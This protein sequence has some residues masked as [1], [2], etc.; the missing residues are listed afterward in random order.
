MQTFAV[1]Q[2][3]GTRQELQE[4]I[5]LGDPI[6]EATSGQIPQGQVFP[7]QHRMLTETELQMSNMPEQ[8]LRTICRWRPYLDRSSLYFPLQISLPALPAGTRLSPSSLQ[9]NLNMQPEGAG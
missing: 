9:T 4:K 7:R 6:L 2:M 8:I 1:Q 3:H 5:L